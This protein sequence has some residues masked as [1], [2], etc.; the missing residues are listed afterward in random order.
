MSLISPLE[1]DR[2]IKEETKSPNLLRLLLL[3]YYLLFLFVSLSINQSITQ[4]ICLLHL[5]LPLLPLP[6]PLFLCRLISSL[7]KCESVPGY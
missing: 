7:Y 3:H 1:A 4:L 2:R 6:L 5:R